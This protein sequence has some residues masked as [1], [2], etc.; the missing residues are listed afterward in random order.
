MPR[1]EERRTVAASDQVCWHLLTDPEQIPSWL[2]VASSV[3]SDDDPGTGQRLRV[4]GGAL[5][6]SVDLDVEVVAWDPP[7]RYGWRLTDPIDVTLTHDLERTAPHRCTLT[8]TVDADVGRR[9][10][11]R[12][13]VA[14]RVLRG[15]L[16]TS[17]DRFVALAEDEPAD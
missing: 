7:G 4:R 3:R 11:M 10:S 1:F 9:P 15:E 13:R 14:I 5:G 16:A 6:V 2:T 12:T 17:L 8:T